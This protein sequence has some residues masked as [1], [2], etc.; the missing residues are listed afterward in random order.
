[1]KAAIYCRLSEEDKQKNN[2]EMDSCSIQNQKSMLLQYA[3]QQGWEVFGIYS[4][5]D[6]AGADRKRPEFN[7]LLRDAENRCFEVVL[8]KTQSRFTRELEMVEKYIHGLFPQW[9]IRFISIVDNADTDNKGNKKSRQINGLVNE[10]Y[11]EDMSE[12]IRSVLTSR[13]RCGLH[14]GAFALYGYKK[15]AENKGRLLIDEEAARIVREVFRLFSMG[16]GKSAIAEILNK[17]HIPAPA[18]YKRQQG[19]RYRQSHSEASKLWKYYTVAEMLR[20]EMYIGTMVQ[21]KFG[22]VSYKS[23]E[24]KPIPKDKWIRVEN[25]HEAIIERELWDRV[26]TLLKERSRPFRLGER[27]VF[28]GKIICA[29]CGYAMISTRSRGEKYF[30]CPS[31][32]LGED[33]CNGAFIKESELADIIMRKL[34]KLYK[35][36]SKKDAAEEQRKYLQRLLDKQ[37]EIYDRQ[38]DYEQKAATFGDALKEIYL[39]KVRGIIT[40]AEFGEFA[41]GFRSEKSQYIEKSISC[42]KEIEVI[43]QRIEAGDNRKELL[44]KYVGEEALTQEMVETLIKRIEVGKR[45]SRNSDYPVKIIWKF[46]D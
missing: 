4:D 44:E 5:D 36:Y 15:D 8:C 21:G 6:Y 43:K 2:E 28:A 23:K 17:M 39:D 25:T 20:N 27:S 40:D 26:Q 33:I 9:G 22:S 29:G 13:R 18:E 7:R 16:Y 42:Q 3:L 14:I 11:L 41:A 37:K 38:T 32:K 24:N 46:D 10:W 35:E 45:N 12:N 1:M 30:K 31:R 19:L 34:H